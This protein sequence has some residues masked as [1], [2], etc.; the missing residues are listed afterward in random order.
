VSEP[1]PRR[2]HLDHIQRI[3]ADTY[4]DTRHRPVL[5][6]DGYGVRVH[7][8]DGHLIIDDGIGDHRRTRQLTRAQR[9]VKRLVI[10]SRTGNLTLDAIRWCTDTGITLI[11]ARHD[12]TL[13]LIAAPDHHHDARLRRAQALATTSTVGLTIA[14]HLITGKLDGHARNLVDLGADPNIV[15]DH[16]PTVESATSTTELLDAESRAA[17]D[18]FSAWAGRVHVLFTGRAARVPDHWRTFTARTTP[19]STSR[20]NRRAVDPVNALLNY[21]YALG[22][23]ES[24]RACSALGLD[25]ALGVLHHD[26]AHRDSLALDLLEPLR[27]VIERTVLDLIG[28]RRF[29]PIDFVETP[30]GQCRLTESVTHPL[31]E[32]MTGWARVLAPIVEH[33]AATF[34]ASATGKIRTRTPLTNSVRIVAA[35][36]GRKT[37]TVQRELTLAGTARVDRRCEHCGRVLTGAA[38]KVCA[39]CRPEQRRRQLADASVTARGDTWRERITSDS[40]RQRRA[41]GI[42]ANRAETIRWETEHGR[43]PIDRAAYLRDT[44]PLL[45]DLTTVDVA[46]ALGVSQSAA[47][48]I[49]TGKLVPHVRHWASLHALTQSTNTDDDTP[50]DE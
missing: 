2:E 42:A 23:A 45:T 8:R 19:L 31:A 16:L 5:V 4:D 11:C 29:G 47:S 20:S 15:T 37:R 38:R 34:A 33:V 48:R 36:P 3:L 6:A 50:V 17:A 18:Y 14:R 39:D 21:G 26:R 25:P 1:T 10:L 49:R 30:D 40:A 44:V 9:T 24:R 32:S 35:Q 28:R 43:E 22:E 27:A 7:V 46:R 13:D 41:A 12:G